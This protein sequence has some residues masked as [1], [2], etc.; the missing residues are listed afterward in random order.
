MLANSADPDVVKVGITDNLHRRVGQ[1]NSLS[2]TVG[3]WSILKSFEIPEAFNRAEVEQAALESLQRYRV[4]SRREQFKVGYEEAVREVESAIFVF[5]L[6]EVTKMVE[7]TDPSDIDF[8][9][10][11][12]LK[13]AQLANIL[14]LKLCDENG[15]IPELNQSDVLR[16]RAVVERR[17]S[18]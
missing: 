17:L 18:Q 9:G 13:M 11:E 5:F 2:S 15:E 12:G 1:M 7:N 10:E 14:Y 6:K 16:I 8:E 3:E 4:L